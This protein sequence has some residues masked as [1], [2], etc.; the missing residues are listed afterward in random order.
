MPVMNRDIIQLSV[1]FQLR[2][3][4]AYLQ[5]GNM[6]VAQIDFVSESA[7]VRGYTNQTQ[8]Q[9]ERNRRTAV[10]RVDI[11]LRSR[12]HELLSR[13]QANQDTLHL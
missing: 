11:R 13:R 9:R 6:K 5:S 10:S 3:N 2:L 7:E 12:H 4:G 8:D 1:D